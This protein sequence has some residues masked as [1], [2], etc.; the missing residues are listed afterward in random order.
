MQVAYLEKRPSQFHYVYRRGIKW[1]VVKK[2]LQMIRAEGKRRRL[3]FVLAE[4]RRFVNPSYSTDWSIFTQLTENCTLEE[5]IWGYRNY[6]AGGLD[7]WVFFAYLFL[8]GVIGGLERLAIHCE[9][10]DEDSVVFRVINLFLIG[11]AIVWAFHLVLRDLRRRYDWG[12]L[13]QTVTVNHIEDMESEVSEKPSPGS[14]R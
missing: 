5:Y 8:I 12:Q 2:Y 1:K 9:L 13:W 11:C 4:L 3:S 10:L 6:L 14:I 7:I